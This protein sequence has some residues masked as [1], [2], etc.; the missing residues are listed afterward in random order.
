MSTREELNEERTKLVH[1]IEIQNDYVL[2]F[3]ATECVQKFALAMQ[4]QVSDIEFGALLT[5]T[6]TDCIQ[7]INDLIA[8][9]KDL[10]YQKFMEE[11]KF[12]YESSLEQV[13]KFRQALKQ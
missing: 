9:E 7:E 2:T 6:L 12:C 5:Q 8:K 11:I 4:S 10:P 3:K 13:F 1:F